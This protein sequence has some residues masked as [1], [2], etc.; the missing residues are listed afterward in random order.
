[1]RTEKGLYTSGE[2]EMSPWQEDLPEPEI[3]PSIFTF[4]FF[5]LTPFLSLLR[6]A[7][8]LDLLLLCSL[9]PPNSVGTSHWLLSKVWPSKAWPNVHISW[10]Q[11]QQTT[12]DK[13]KKNKLLVVYS[14]H[15]HPKEFGATLREKQTEQTGREAG[16][17][18]SSFRA[19]NYYRI[20]I[21]FPYR[22]A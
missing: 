3:S 8:P 6:G 1:M 11:Q 20:N 4:F 7:Q 13:W 16:L 9:N 10:L 14:L 2:W 15:I 22:K 19:I 21:C 12:A 5:V 17:S 18:T